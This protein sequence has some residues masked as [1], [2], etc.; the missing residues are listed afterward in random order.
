MS[1]CGRCGLWQKTPEDERDQVWSGVCLWYH[2]RLERESV[3]EK[4]N[5]PDYMERIPPYSPDW[6]F[7]HKI[8]RENLGDAFEK[9]KQADKKS[10]IAIGFSV[11][12]LI[13]SLT[14]LIVG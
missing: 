6:H 4:R 1:R 12:G 8:K 10:V 11:V 5:C 9:S 14:K 2:L 3:F 13:I 7:E